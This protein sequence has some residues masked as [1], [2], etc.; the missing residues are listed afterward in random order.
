MNENYQAMTEGVQHFLQ[1]LGLPQ[2]YEAF[3]TK[4]YDMETDLL[5]LNDDDLDEMRITQKEHRVVLKRKASQHCLSQEYRLHVWLQENGLDYYFVNFVNGELTDFEEI[6]QM[7]LPDE[8]IFDELEIMLPGHKKRL[9]KAVLEL[10]RKRRSMSPEFESPVTEG[11]WGK[12]E[13][14]QEAKY[15]FLC[16]DALLSSTK[17]NVDDSQRLQFMVDSGSDV[18]T[19]REEILQKLDLELIGPIQSRGVHASKTKNLYKAT[20]LIGN[21]ELEIEVM[22][23][24]YDSIGSRVIRHFRHYISGGRHVWLKGDYYDPSMSPKER[25]TQSQVTVESSATRLEQTAA[26]ETSV[27]KD[28]SEQSESETKLEK[29]SSTSSLSESYQHSISGARPEPDMD[30]SRPRKRQRISEDIIDIETSED[31]ESFH[32]RQ[33]LVQQSPSPSPHNVSPVPPPLISPLSPTSS[34]S[35]QIMEQIGDRSSDDPGSNI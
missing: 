13:F 4:G 7:K 1:E 11:W 35:S 9:T 30:D 26:E 3:V 28:L 24:T 5:D 18:V 21:E 16:V 33:I 14:L 25:L 12:P 32:S 2:Y 17:D 29:T 27:Y 19:V 20:L 34:S 22:G 15:D 31:L 8:K 10:R 23:E 6:A